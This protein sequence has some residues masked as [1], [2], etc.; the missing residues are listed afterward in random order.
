[1]PR[2]GSMARPQLTE[3]DLDGQEQSKVRAKTQGGVIL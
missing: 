2:V 1:M 3:R